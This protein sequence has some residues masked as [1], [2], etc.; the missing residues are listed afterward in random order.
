MELGLCSPSRTGLELR[1]RIEGFVEVVGRLG[2][3]R[4][5]PSGCSLLIMARRRLVGR[6]ALA[7]NASRW[8]VEAGT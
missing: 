2:F 5:R 6:V 8:L 1:S 4:D 7:C 3:G